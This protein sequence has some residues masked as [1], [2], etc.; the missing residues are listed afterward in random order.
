MDVEP[1]I[2]QLQAVLIE[3]NR[4]ENT[5]PRPNMH[6]MVTRLSAAIGRIAPPGSAYA[7]QAALALVGA[8]PRAVSYGLAGVAQALRDDLKAGY[9]ESVVEL[10]HASVFSDFL[11]M[12][13]ELNAGFKDAAAVIAGS[14]LEGHLRKLADRSS[15]AAAKPDGSPKKAS[16]LNA[17]LAADGAYNKLEEKSVTA[18]LDLWNKA[19][20]GEYDEYDH[21]QVAALIR[22]VREFSDSSPG[23]TQ[24]GPP[25]HQR[26]P[27]A[28][29]LRGSADLGYHSS[30]SRRAF[31]TRCTSR[32]RCASVIRRPDDA[33]AA[34]SSSARVPCA[35]MS[36]PCR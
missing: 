4:A 33:P 27:R 3:Y 22:D 30:Q 1:L 34:A 26:R 17:E 20:H 9:L 36:A 19:A 35:C 16:T 32:C 25:G 6:A 7:K 28:R 8:Q 18:W 13:T 15:V 2:A 5:T 11:E 10:V 29:G 12:A 24:K 14:V 31:S 21:G 23:V